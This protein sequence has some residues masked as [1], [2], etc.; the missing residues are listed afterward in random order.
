MEKMNRND[1][2]CKINGIMYRDPTGDM[3]RIKSVLESSIELI[4]NMFGAWNEA[5]YIE[6]VA[7]RQGAMDCLNESIDRIMHFV[8]SVDRWLTVESHEKEVYHG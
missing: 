2:L 6:D 8:H 4:Q 5:T 1:D 7:V 3:R